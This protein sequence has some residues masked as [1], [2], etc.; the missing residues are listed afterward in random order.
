[1]SFTYDITGLGGKRNLSRGKDHVAMPDGLAV[2]TDG[3][4]GLV[5][6]NLL[7]A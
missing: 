3:G 7:Y 5:S 1:M 6:L 2:G 4:W